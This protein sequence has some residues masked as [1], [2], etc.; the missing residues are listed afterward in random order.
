MYI[1]S[2]IP[3]HLGACLY[4]NGSKRILGYLY[5]SND[6]GLVQDLSFENIDFEFRAVLILSILYGKRQ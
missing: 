1:E 6:L 4:D 3:L 5:N 2:H